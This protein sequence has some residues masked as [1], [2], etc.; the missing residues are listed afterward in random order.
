MHFS[1]RN[2]QA[3]QVGRSS[4]HLTFL[5]LQALH[6]S[7]D[8]VAVDDVDLAGDGADDSAFDD[9]GPDDEVASG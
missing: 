2:E 5:L 9:E 6:P 7:L 8:F 1:R 4:S 3:R